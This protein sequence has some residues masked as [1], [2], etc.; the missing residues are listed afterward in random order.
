MPNVLG[1]PAD[2]N[3]STTGDTTAAAPRPPHVLPE[4]IGPYRII[5]CIGEGGMGIVYKAE[6]RE[7]VRRVVALKI[8]KLGMDT[9]EVVARFDVERQALA[10]MSHPNVAKVFDAGMT[11]TGRPYFA[12]EHVSGV[13]I[14]SY[15][16][17]NKL[18]T[19]ERLE[20]FIPVCQAVQHAHQK[21]IIHRDLKPGNI[22]V[23]MFDGK[24]VPKVIDFGV[25]KATNFHL[26]EKTL[27]TQAG[28]VVGTVEY[29]SPE[30]AT[31]SGLDVDTRTDIYSLGVIL[32]QL[33]TGTLPFESETL[34]KVSMD[35]M[36]R[37]IRDT[38]PPKP[39]A[40]LTETL[41]APS[42]NTPDADEIAK[43]HHTDPRTL[44]KELKGDLDW[45]VLKAMEKDRTRRYETA[46]GLAMDLQRH[47]ADEPVSA[48][49]PSPIYRVAKFA[50]RHRVGVSAA[51]AI[52]IALLV[53]LTTST[54]AF[55]RE[56]AA[57]AQADI[58]AQ[59][60]NGQRLIAQQKEHEAEQAKQ[61]AQN[62]NA[63][64]QDILSDSISKGIRK[65]PMQTLD[66]IAR[67]VDGGGLSLDP[68]TEARVRSILARN[69]ASIGLYQRAASQLQSAL[70]TRMQTSAAPGDLIEN[71]NELADAQITCNQLTG[72]EQY[73]LQ[74]AAIEHDQR[75]VDPEAQAWT[76]DLHGSILAARGDWAAAKPLL[77][78]SLAVRRGLGPG[79][80]LADSLAHNGESLLA[81]HDDNGRALLKQA[82]DMYV[83]ILGSQ[84]TALIGPLRRMA[85]AAAQRK[86]WSE[87]ATIDQALHQRRTFDQPQDLTLLDEWISSM[88][89]V[90]NSGPPNAELMVRQGNIYGRRGD[91]RQAAGD[92]L[93]ALKLPLP[94]GLPVRLW[95]WCLPLLLQNGQP[96]LYR[97]NRHR[98][99]TQFSNATEPQI[100]HAI[101]KSSLCLDL[102]GEDL[103]I[104]CDLADRAFQAN[105]VDGFYLQAMGMAEYRR[106]NDDKAIELLTKSCDHVYAYRD[107]LGDF[108]IAM[109]QARSG[110][111]PEANS[112][113]EKGLV[114][115]NSSIPKPGKDDLEQFEDWVLCY[116]ARREAQQ[117]VSGG[118]SPAPN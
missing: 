59:I 56:R 71:L 43:R 104:A 42:R 27:F 1:T 75:P 36:A 45:I 94:R 109:A 20:L 83:N 115:W 50:R 31:G 79:R 110:K 39:S 106:G 112:A 10:L 13:S 113:M 87:W 23:T 105:S 81:Q 88:S 7:P 74:A 37:I 98:L 54:I 57:K 82:R 58:S 28:S 118:P 107:A 93:A 62:E 61:I 4:S 73:V 32:Y 5:E 100:A 96:E 114:L 63:F 89:A 64:L 22:L 111:M 8:I 95:H 70:A 48:R 92:F 16:D 80:P 90:L 99:L 67:R 41:R 77:E 14:T 52:V 86:D 17:T 102:D 101:S 11:E 26:T 19:R 78:Q 3:A 69:Y 53:G 49:P 18:T 25:A 66:D 47:L 30:Q 33:L 108:Y 72:A 6:Q 9:K 85:R 68:P 35:E 44:R 2:V 46:N 117:R 103:T 55:V 24:P 29:M 116:L 21:G 76:S 91:F 40:R 38:D 84:P 60:A 65:S 15:C 97:Q 34:R 51:A 12:M